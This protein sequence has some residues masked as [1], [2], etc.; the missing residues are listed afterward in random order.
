M[1]KYLLYLI[2]ILVTTSGCVS[3]TLHEEVLGNL[4][5]A[6]VELNN[7][8]NALKECIRTTEE[9]KK[10]RDLLTQA[11]TGEV[12][13]LKDR[14]DEL[15]GERNDLRGKN[16]FLERENNRL[17][18]KTGELSAQKE[19]ELAEMRHTYENLV[20][21]ME[22]EIES[23][24]IKITQAMD[25]LSVNFVEK[26]LFDS[27]KSKIKPAGMAVLKRVGDILKKV[28]DK[29]I[30]VEGHTDNVPIGV[31]LQKKFATNWELSAVRATTVVRFLDSE[32]GLAPAHMSAAG[33]S[34]YKSVATNDTK[35]G[36]AENRRIEIV[37]LPMDV[38]RVLDELKNSDGMSPASEP[39][40]GE[41]MNSDPATSESATTEPTTSA[42][43]IEPQA[44][45]PMTIEPQASEPMVIEPMTSQPIATTPITTEPI[46][47]EPVTNE[48]TP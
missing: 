30:R 25:K 39:M 36:R 19:K 22:S 14:L 34:H 37:L 21:E 41:S 3:K 28:T 15:K 45:E 27:G 4:K 44:G 26:I 18:Q 8:R 42:M 35:D 40:S 11:M 24:Q 7:V 10:D 46:A 13:N 29:Q 33:Y 23:G 5:V 17:M 48:P 6:N 9:L 16:D 20:G 2:M 12:S 1:K 38:D 32:V 43:T 31:A 47:S